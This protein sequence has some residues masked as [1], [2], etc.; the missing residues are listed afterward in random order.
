M[1]ILSLHSFSENEMEFTMEFYFRQY[2][3][4]PRLA[5][6]KIGK[7]DSIQSNFEMSKLI[8]TPDTFFVREKESFLYT[9]T[10]KN[11]FLKI[12]SNGDVKRSQ[13]WGLKKFPR[14]FLNLYFQR[15]RH[16]FVSNELS[17]FPDG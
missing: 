9:M 8:W 4:D 5:F 1:Y 13:R 12:D 10:A 6:Q 14:V 17:S 15:E 16:I 2:W 11:E 3:N 7:L